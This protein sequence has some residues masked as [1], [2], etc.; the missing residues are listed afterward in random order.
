MG[1]LWP[2]EDRATAR[3]MESFYRSLSAGRSEAEALAD[4][5]RAAL[6]DSA[7]AHPFYWAGLGIFARRD[8]KP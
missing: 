8:G 1:T 4:A 6:R 3:L 7:I 2:I 5:Q